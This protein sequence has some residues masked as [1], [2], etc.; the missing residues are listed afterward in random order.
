MFTFDEEVSCLE[1][2]I[3]RIISI[4][5]QHLKVL[6]VFFYLI[7]KFETLYSCLGLLWFFEIKEKLLLVV[8]L[9]LT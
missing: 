2:G 5:E 1:P 3:V 9:C 6:Y 8:E 4:E 7:E